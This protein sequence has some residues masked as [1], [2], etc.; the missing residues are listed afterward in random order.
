MSIWKL[1]SHLSFDFVEGEGSMSPEKMAII[2]KYSAKFN[3]WDRLVLY[4]VVLV[5]ITDILV[6]LYQ[7]MQFTQDNISTQQQNIFTGQIL[8]VIAFS[9][10]VTIIRVV[11]CKF[12][13]LHPTL[14][15]LRSVL[16]YTGVVEM[17][18]AIISFVIAIGLSLAVAILAV[19][20][21]QSDALLITAFAIL[22]YVLTLFFYRL[23]IAAYITRM[24]EENA[25]GLVPNV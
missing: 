5:L 3:R 14:H 2:K 7:T 11:I 22:S 23:H 17:G 16:T 25:A 6:L 8:F 1:F 15:V 18:L 21:N 9:F 20:N 13:L 10:F 4:P 19:E 12:L 24:C